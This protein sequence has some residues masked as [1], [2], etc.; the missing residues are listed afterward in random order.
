[1]LFSKSLSEITAAD[2]Q[3]VITRQQQEDIET[4]FKEAL[5][6]RNGD[7]DK[8][9]I[10]Q[11]G[12]GNAAKEALTKEIIAF[13]NTQGGTL[14]LGIAED[15]DKRASRIVEMPKCRDLAERLG[16]SIMS[17]TDPKITT[18]EVVGVPINGDAGVVVFQVPQS[19]R[20]PHRD[21]NSRE[22]YRRRNDSSEPMM[23][24]EV[25]DLTLDRTR[26]FKRVEDRLNEGAG[27]ICEKPWIHSSK[28]HGAT[29]PH[30]TPS[31]TQ[32]RSLYLCASRAVAVPF[33]PVSLG[34][35]IDNPRLKLPCIPLI[36]VNNQGQR[37][38]N[39]QRHA[40]WSPIIRGIREGTNRPDRCDKHL[41]SINSDGRVVVEVLK[42]EYVMRDDLQGIPAV[43]LLEPFAEL[44]ATTH[45]L[46]SR[47][48]RKDLEFALLFEWRVSSNVNLLPSQLHFYDPIRMHET[49]NS[50]TDY[51]L[52]SGDNFGELF[53]LIERDFWHAAGQERL[54]GSCQY[55]L[56]AS[57]AKLK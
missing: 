4:E 30:S 1:M 57:L 33:E 52:S 15:G 35:L 11:T 8:W 13:A 53:S 47:M 41:R 3:A 6:G 43:W 25:Q 46:R 10:D 40:Q 26:S 55:D 29:G 2:I 44:I 19:V 16:A 9:M 21:S 5:S 48:G 42:P 28:E 31:G 22:C 56:P 39:N 49:Y 7:P 51:Q 50:I 27:L 24:R 38:I 14:I 34:N 32:A 45:L 54:V 17:S 18:L 36:A 20:A 37:E 23:M 12:I